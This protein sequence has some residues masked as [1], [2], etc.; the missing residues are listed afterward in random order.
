MKQTNNSRETGKGEQIE[1]YCKVLNRLQN[2][3]RF[4]RISM[5]MKKYYDSLNILL[6]C[7][8]ILEKNK[9]RKRMSEN[10]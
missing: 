6:L 8:R 9:E 5:F 10:I 2:I 7:K 1:V 4:I 3:R